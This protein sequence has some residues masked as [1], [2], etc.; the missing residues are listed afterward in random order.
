MAFKQYLSGGAGKNVPSRSSV[1]CLHDR[2]SSVTEQLGSL[3]SGKRWQCE[4]DTGL[5]YQRAGEECSRLS[6]VIC[7]RSN[8]FPLSNP[9]EYPNSFLPGIHR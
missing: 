8:S 9:K 1:I 3:D 5:D 4:V 7:L 6:C 2:V